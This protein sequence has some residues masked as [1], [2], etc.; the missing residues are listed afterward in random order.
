VKI[1]SRH[2]VTFWLGFSFHI[3]FIYKIV[4]VTWMPGIQQANCGYI[5]MLFR[6]VSV[7]H[8]SLR[9]SA[10]FL[11]CIWFSKQIEFLFCSENE[12]YFYASTST[13]LIWIPDMD[14]IPNMDASYGWMEA[15]L[16]WTQDALLKR[17]YIPA[18]LRHFN[19]L[20]FISIENEIQLE[21]FQSIQMS[22]GKLN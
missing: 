6:F 22:F 3:F 12:I 5:D 15:Y 13:Y 4:L 11:V 16:M 1:L 14:G 10:G 20:K 2:A 18:F 7:L 8:W 17:L 21:C 9:S 19:T